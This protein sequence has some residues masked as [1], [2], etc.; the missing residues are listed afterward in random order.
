M[1]I[2]QHIDM[3][4][5]GY[6]LR[7]LRRLDI[8]AW[9]AYLKIPEVIAHT[10]WNLSC[11]DDLLPQFEEYE[12]DALNSQI[13]LAIVCTQTGQLAGTVG[14]HT[15]STLN[16][17]A[18]IAYDLAP[19]FWGRRIAQSAAEA[20]CGWGFAEFNLNRIQATVLESNA[21]SLKL[22]ERLGFVREGY[23]KAFRMVRGRPGNFW[24]YAR[25]NPTITG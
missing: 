15:I 24:M 12:S 18:E 5:E 6:A 1:Q 10:S 14:F 21:N 2:T 20:L 8:P 16:H 25:L 22:I 4:H 17:S 19:Q 3:Q 11:A 7:T 13:R 9:Y 23:L